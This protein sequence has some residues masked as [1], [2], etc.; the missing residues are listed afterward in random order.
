MSVSFFLVS[1]VTMT[2]F[3]VWAGLRKDISVIDIAWGVGFVLLAVIP[4]FLAEAILPR[5]MLIAVFVILWGV[6]LS[7]YIFLRIRKNGED[8]RYAAFRKAWGDSFYLRS[9]VQIFLVQAVLQFIIALPILAI[10]TSQITSFS[11]LDSLGISLWFIGFIIETL[12][13]MQM[14]I[15]K[16]NPANKGKLMT[17]GLWKYSR[18]PNYFGEICMWWGIFFIAASIGQVW[19]IISPLVITYLLVFVSGI[20]LLEEKMSDYPEFPE[21]KKKTSILFPW[22]QKEV[23]Q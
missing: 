21:Y 23:T 13:D 17:T 6:R 19:T 22:F 12:A 4:L 9:Y 5:Q 3:Y 11:V 16:S 8:Y 14:Y 2:I 18:H 10:H 7:S 15:F 20:P 1:I